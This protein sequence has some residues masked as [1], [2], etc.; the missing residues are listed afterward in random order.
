MRKKAFFQSGL[1]NPRVLLAFVFCAFALLLVM[2][3]FVGTLSSGTKAKA[4]SSARAKNATRPCILLSARSFSARPRLPIFNA[5]RASRST[6][7]T[8]TATFGSRARLERRRS[9]PGSNARSTMATNSTSLARPGCVPTHP[10]RRRYRP[11]DRRSGQR[12][13]IDLEALTNLG[14]SVSNDNGS[15]WRKNPEC[16]QVPGVDR[17]WFATDNGSNHTLGAAGAADNTIFAQTTI[18]RSAQSSIPRPARPV[19]LMPSVDSS[20]PAQQANRPAPRP[21]DPVR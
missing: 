13:F 19:R 16:M 17:Q 7:W 10:L 20:T 14:C 15:T 2:F 1:F 21:A 3:G 4:G 9:N 5:S 12:Y 8:K 18:R 11:D 6:M